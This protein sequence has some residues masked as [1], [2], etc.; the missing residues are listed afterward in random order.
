M[1]LEFMD[2]FDYYTSGNSPTTQGPRKWNLGAGGVVYD[3]TTRSGVG[4]YAVPDVLS[5]GDFGCA[6][7][8]VGRTKWIVGFAFRVGP[9]TGLGIG[10]NTTFFTIRDQ[11]G[12]LKFSISVRSD[13]AVIVSNG[14][15]QI[16]IGV[17][18]ITV[19]NWYQIGCLV[20]FSASYWELYINNVKVAFNT[21]L[22][23]P[24]ASPNCFYLNAPEPVVTHNFDDFFVF[25]GTGTTGV[26]DVFPGDLRVDVLLPAA[27]GAHSDLNP[28]PHPANWQNV[29]EI[30][31]DDDVSLNNTNSAGAKDYYKYQQSA[32]VG[33]I[34]GIQVNHVARKGDAG[35]RTFAA[36]CLSGGV[37]VPSSSDFSLTNNYY[38]YRTVYE[39]DPATGV[40]WLLGA[41]PGS[42]SGINDMQLG[43]ELKS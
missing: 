40:R 30:P 27:P 4:G 2:G 10:T 15:G 22:G 21:N 20:D 6:L 29:N 1:K 5:G 19:Q 7:D 3:G 8:L 23:S 33:T 18:P 28:S 26:D 36:H 37:D 16:G 41:G 32:L 31:T 38:N 9:L 39:T 42:G 14:P 12:A 25:S 11:L 24:G 13:G 34:Y 35:S 43:V 17:D